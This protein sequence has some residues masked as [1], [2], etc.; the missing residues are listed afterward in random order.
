M[1]RLTVLLAVL[2]AGCSAPTPNQPAAVVFDRCGGSGAV[3]NETTRQCERTID[4][5]VWVEAGPNLLRTP[6]GSCPT[7]FMAHPGFA[8]YCDLPQTVATYLLNHPVVVEVPTP[9]VQPQP[10]VQT[11]QLRVM[12]EMAETQR[13]MR[14]D[15]REAAVQAQRA[16]SEE[17]LRQGY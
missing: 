9:I 8:G 5:R 16:A 4:G 1:S 12:R 7:G 14:N 13:S 17:R 6:D 2:C 3:F 15:A 10:D 11:A